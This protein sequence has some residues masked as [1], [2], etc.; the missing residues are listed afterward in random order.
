[1]PLKVPNYGSAIAKFLAQRLVANQT[2][3]FG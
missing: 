2:N 3:G 1:V